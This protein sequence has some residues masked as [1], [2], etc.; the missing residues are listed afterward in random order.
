MK[1]LHYLD[2]EWFETKDLKISAFDLSVLRGYGIFDFLRTYNHK[3]FRLKEHIDRLYNSARILNLPMRWKREEI[4]QIVAEGIEKNK[5][6]HKDFNIRI[7]VTGGVG[8]DST[9][10]GNPSLMVIFSGAIDYPRDYYEKGVKII[11]HQY[12]RNLPDAK[13]L[14]YLIGIQVLQKAKSQGAIEVIYV[15]N[16]GKIYEGTTSN[17]FFV[18]DNELITPKSDILVGVTRRVLF[19]LAKKLKVPCRETDIWYNDIPTF[20]ECFITASNKEIMPVV[21]IDDKTVGN[22]AVGEITNLLL[23][24]YRKLTT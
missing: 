9:T 11:T 2:G 13:T 23:S 22:G 3:P 1:N 15:Y 17:I 18:K 21:T 4:E 12:L 10:P 20:D 7:V 6:V 5:D 24:E 16:D 8:A 14:N 19:E